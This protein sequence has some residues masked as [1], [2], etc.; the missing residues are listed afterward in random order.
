MIKRN[1]DV[2]VIGG[3]H[4]G[5]EAAWAAANALGGGHVALITMDPSRIGAMSCNPAIGGLAKGQIAREI[6]ALGGL[7]GRAIDASG[8]MFKVLNQSRG[9]A[10]R[11]PRAQADKY[12]YPRAVQDLI[13]SHPDIT[14]IA[15]TVDELLVENAKCI[16]VRLPIGAGISNPHAEENLNNFEG[17][18]PPRFSSEPSSRSSESIDLHASSIVLTTGTFLKGLMHEGEK[19]TIGGRTGEGSSLGL[20]SELSRLGFDLGRLKT[21]TP[22]R[23]DRSS[24]DWESLPIQTGDNF[25]IPFS[26]LTERSSFPLIPQ[27]ECRVTHTTIEAH[28]LIRKNLH[29]APMYS[30]ALDAESG[31]RYCP[32]IED[33]VVRFKERSSHHVFLEPESLDTNEIYANGISTSLPLEIQ[34]EVVRLMPG[35]EKATLLKPGYAVEYDVSWPHQIDATAMTKLVDGLF[36]AG[37]LNGTSGYEEAGGQGVLAGLNAARY[38]KGND[39]IRLSRD[40]AYIGVM[41]DDL[42]TKQPREPYRMFTSRAEHRLRLRADTT[43]SRL[44]PLGRGWGLVGDSRWKKWEE[45]NEMLQKI[46]AEIEISTLHGKPMGQVIKRPELQPIEVQ[47]KLSQEWPLHL[48]ERIMHDRRYDSYIK[49][50]DIEIR[51][52]SELDAYC[53]PRTLNFSNIEGLRNEAKESLEKFQ[54][55][56]IGQAA[57]LAGVSPADVQIIRIALISRGSNV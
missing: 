46:D 48:V 25:P 24:I 12:R 47:E 49:R 34:Q 31:P 35:C 7:M 6:D 22:P 28:S 30:G 37:Q 1:W 14:I 5:T 53:I 29:R 38:V 19:K 52:Q 2:L 13:A 11:G 36:L 23:L 44:T 10:V 45:R 39:L 56:T 20:S 4:A 8:I 9:P 41:M 3:G 32:S 40:Q 33:K 55:A 51:K 42:V 54:P 21:G 43:D 17:P 50:G 18:C 57:R 26:D 15:S 16:G 27:I